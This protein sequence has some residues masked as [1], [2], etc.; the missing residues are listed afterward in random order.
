MKDLRT[1][2]AAII[3]AICMTLAYLGIVQIDQSTQN[4][5][6]TFTLLIIG[7]FASDAKSNNSEY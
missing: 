4:L 2:V 6:L 3:G 5:I 1:T 7:Y